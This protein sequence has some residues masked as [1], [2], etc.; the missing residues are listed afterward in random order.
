MIFRIWSYTRS[1]RIHTRR[2]TRKLY[3]HNRWHRDTNGTSFTIAPSWRWR[4]VYEW[5]RAFV[6]WQRVFYNH[7]ILQ[8][9]KKWIRFRPYTYLP[10][11]F[12]F[13]M[14]YFSSKYGRVQPRWGSFP[15]KPSRCSRWHR[16]R[17]QNENCATIKIS[18]LL[19]SFEL[20]FSDIQMHFC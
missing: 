20:K 3:I 19:C 16:S 12:I 4:R 14:G 7:I 6:E 9:T 2:D 8:M 15:R 17:I 5:H 1:S 18:Q 13:S 11:I 10:N